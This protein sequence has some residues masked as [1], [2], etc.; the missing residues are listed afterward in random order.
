MLKATLETIAKIVGGNL[1]TISMKDKVVE[2]VSTDTRDIKVQNLFIP[3]VGD[4]IL[5]LMLY[6][7]ERLLLY[8]IKNILLLIL[9]Q[10]LL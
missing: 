9:M 4:I 8:G 1:V 5:S 6:K 7:K 10:E 3:L 2:G